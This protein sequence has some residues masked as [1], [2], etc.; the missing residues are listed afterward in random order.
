MSQTKKITESEFSEIKLLQSKFQEIIFKL[1][2]LGVEKIELDR[3]VSE[4]VEKEKNLKNEWTTI[5]KLEHTLLDKM[6]KTYGIGN[7]NMTDGTFT[8]TTE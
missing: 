4:F 8:S 3:M 2:N 6:I 7:L 1:G 5:Q